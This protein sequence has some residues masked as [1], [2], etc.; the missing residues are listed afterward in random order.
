MSTDQMH[1]NESTIESPTH[2]SKKHHQGK[3]GESPEVTITPGHHNK[4][5]T[6]TKSSTHKGMP[7][8]VKPIKSP[9]AAEEHCDLESPTSVQMK[10]S[11]LLKQSD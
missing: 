8:K 10:Q 7:K 2:K 1:E 6:N 11:F 5:M 9:K 3:S 4:T